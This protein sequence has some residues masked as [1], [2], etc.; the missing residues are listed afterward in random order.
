MTF[1]IIKLPGDK[2]KENHQQQ[3]RRIASWIIHTEQ[4]NRQFPTG[5]MQV[6]WQWDGTEP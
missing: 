4:V 1:I 5:M 2:D 3:G 6:R